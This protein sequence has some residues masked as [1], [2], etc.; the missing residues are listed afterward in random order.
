MPIIVLLV[1]IGLPLFEIY[2]MIKV[3][4]HIGALPTVL[5][6]I[7]TA[8]AGAWLV[9]LQGFGILWRIKDT[10]ARDEIPAREV[11][12]GALLLVAGLFLILPGFF[13]DTLGFLLLI[14]PLRHRLIARYIEAIPIEGA[15]A[16]RGPRV[17]EGQF[18]RDD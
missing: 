3:G 8:L 9:R 2:L 10:M 6:S 1:V 5:L 18:R 13:T 14:P 12:D 4:S 16:H 17:I 7:F 15:T 11:M